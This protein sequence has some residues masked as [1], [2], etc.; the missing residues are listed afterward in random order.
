MFRFTIRDVLWLT[1]VVAL[2][3]AWYLTQK[4]LA[5]VTRRE[6]AATQNAAHYKLL[7]RLTVE[8]GLAPVHQKDGTVTLERISAPIA[9]GTAPLNDP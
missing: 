1:V 3:V 2:A 6:K 9:P 8:A 7:Q 5:E 4:Q